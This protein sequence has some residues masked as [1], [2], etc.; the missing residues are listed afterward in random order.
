MFWLSWT[1]RIRTNPNNNLMKR[2]AGLSRC[3]GCGL[4]LKRNKVA[5]VSFLS[6]L[7]FAEHPIFCNICRL[8]FP[9]VARC[10]KCVHKQNSNLSQISRF[11]A[12]KPSW[13]PQFWLSHLYNFNLILK[14]NFGQYMQKIPKKKDFGRCLVWYG[15]WQLW[16]NNGIA[17]TTSLSES[18]A[19][20]YGG[21]RSKPCWKDKHS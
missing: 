6:F 16:R 18:P 17:K 9:F 3:G 13:W 5:F 8:N 12:S 19:W 1:D 10:R 2:R 4:I 21:Q 7:S 20:L 14:D 11:P 15:H